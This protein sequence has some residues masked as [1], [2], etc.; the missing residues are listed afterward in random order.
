G[1]TQCQ[2]PRYAIA[3]DWRRG[4]SEKV[5]SDKRKLQLAN[6][7]SIYD[8]EARALAR[9][10]EWGK[11]DRYS[12]GF[13]LFDKYLSGGFGQKTGYELVVAAGESKIGKSKFI[14]NIAMHI[15][16]T[17]EK[18]C[19]IPLENDYEEIYNM[20]ARVAGVRTLIDYKDLIY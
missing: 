8:I 4:M 11:T 14:A 18:I 13:P 16:Q 1:R 17:G 12:S 2:T 5:L 20:V 3:A 19:Y 10:N 15:A 6:A 7:V 9:W